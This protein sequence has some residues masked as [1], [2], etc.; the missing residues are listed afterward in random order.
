MDGVQPIILAAQ[1][2]DPDIL[3]MILDK[4]ANLNY[5]LPDKWKTTPLY[6]AL[7]HSFRFT[8]GKME[9]Y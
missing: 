5:A 3:R 1:A 2:G 8:I 4:G 7:F 6:S 9:R